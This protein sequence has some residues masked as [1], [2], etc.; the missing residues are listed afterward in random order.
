M[1]QARA[2][3]GGEIGANG[4]FYEGGKFIATADNAKKHKP[5]YRPTRKQNTAPFVWEVLPENCNAIYPRMGDGVDI[6]HLKATGIAKPFNGVFYEMHKAY[7]DNLISLWN[8]GV[9]WTLLPQTAT[10]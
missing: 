4:E 7:F 6:R 3:V 10:A 2:K 1:A 5:T 8:A 9:R